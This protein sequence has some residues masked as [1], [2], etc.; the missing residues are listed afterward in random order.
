MN[1]RFA[2]PRGIRV[3]TISPGPI[4]TPC[5]EISMAASRQEPSLNFCKA[6]NT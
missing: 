6:S 5:Y 1:G 4:I 3:N 2:T